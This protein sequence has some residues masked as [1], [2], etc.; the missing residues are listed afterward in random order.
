M[1]R[2]SLDEIAATLP[3]PLSEDIAVALGLKRS[4]LG[5]DKEPKSQ[6]EI[7]RTIDIFTS[8]I[9]REHEIQQDVVYSRFAAL[10]LPATVDKFLDPPPLPANAPCYIAPGV[11]LTNEMYAL[12]GPYTDMII[13]IHHLPYF[14]KYLRSSHPNAANGKRFTEVLATR[15]ADLAPLFESR[16][17]PSARNVSIEERTSYK[18]LIGDVCQLLSSILVDMSKEKDR[19]Q[20][21]VAPAT[22]ARL[23]PFL[24][25]WASRYPREFVGDTTGRTVLLL[26][27][28][29]ALLKMVQPMRRTFKGSAGCAMIGCP[30]TSN[31]KACSRC[32]TTRY[33]SP[34]I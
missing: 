3:L 14:A 19:A 10:Y 28:N 15:L 17:S 26:E 27:E 29:I 22:K 12:K 23:I 11:K 2:G 31:L 33:V 1:N 24:K 32:V 8:R 18:N 21:I 4:A 30:A 13:Q 34:D 6:V 16:L 9:K 25:K 5:P 20:A 7:M